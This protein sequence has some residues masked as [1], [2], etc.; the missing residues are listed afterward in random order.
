MPQSDS[1]QAPTQRQSQ[2][3][4]ADVFLSPTQRQSQESLSDVFLPP[5]SYAELPLH[6]LEQII[7]SIPAQYRAVVPA[8]C[9]LWRHAFLH[10]RGAGMQIGRNSNCLDIRMPLANC[11]T[12]CLPLSH[13]QEVRFTPA[14]P[15]VMRRRRSTYLEPV[16]KQLA[17]VSEQLKEIPYQWLGVVL[18]R[19]HILSLDLSSLS[20]KNW[21]IADFR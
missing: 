18:G 16:S 15:A 19:A 13:V 17:P 9:S 21:N 20:L 3:S 6:I 12:D 1:G 11:P 10:S 5:T 2:E 8:V 4:Q 14:I 7:G